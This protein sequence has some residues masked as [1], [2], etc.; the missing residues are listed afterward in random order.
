[1]S[2]QLRRYIE[3]LTPAQKVEFAK[4]AKSSQMYLTHIVRGR[5]KPGLTKCVAIEK[6][7]GGVVRCESLNPKLPWRYLADRRG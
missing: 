4:R 5:R 3:A 2:M 1:M 7:S 6:A